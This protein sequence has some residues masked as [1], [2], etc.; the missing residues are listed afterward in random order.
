MP[1][2]ACA[3]VE[4]TRDLGGLELVFCLARDRVDRER[5]LRHDLRVGRRAEDPSPFYL[6]LL[7]QALERFRIACGSGLR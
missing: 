1:V 6:G 5:R 3:D 2:Q 4:G 7:H